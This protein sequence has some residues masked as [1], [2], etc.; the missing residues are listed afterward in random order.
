M[1]FVKSKLSNYLAQ[2][3]FILNQ[4][5]CALTAINNKLAGAVVVEWSVV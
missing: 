5:F 2:H 4:V 3:T 1:L